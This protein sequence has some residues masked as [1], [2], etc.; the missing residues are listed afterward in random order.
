MFADSRS[1]PSRTA[2]GMY[3]QE[4]QI[5]KAEEAGLIVTAADLAPLHCYECGATI[6]DMRTASTFDDLNWAHDDCLRKP[7]E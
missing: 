7:N 1:Y 3:Q 6:T 5:A 2:R 4:Q